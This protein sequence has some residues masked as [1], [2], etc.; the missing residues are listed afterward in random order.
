MKEK[1]FAPILILVGVLILVAVGG[2]AYYLGTIKNK[3]EQTVIPISET[4]KRT[5]STPT[6]QSISSQDFF[7]TGQY[8]KRLFDPK[9]PY[10]VNT[11]YP[12]ELT[13]LESDNLIGLRCSPR[14]MGV[15]PGGGFPSGF[16]F[17]D[18]S[19]Q[20]ELKEFTDVNLLNLALKAKSLAGNKTILKF[21]YCESENGKRFMEFE[22][23]STR[24]SGYDYIAQDANIASVDNTGQLKMI[25]TIEGYG[26]GP[27]LECNTPLQM[28]KD[29]F[30][31]YD[32]SRSDGSS[33]SKWIIKVNLNS[34]T[35]QAIIECSGVSDT[36]G[37][38][39]SCK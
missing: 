3:S 4:T 17:V 16:A 18:Q 27:Y 5:V 9:K 14:I 29:S 28:T 11:P 30:L 32:C 33:G 24:K 38:K 2:G 35:N 26:R 8:S 34:G 15:N 23:E 19:N 20:G 36:N 31:D 21:Q 37:L 13:S 25:T 39:G 10:F 6:P 12:Q 7:L 1:G 22:A